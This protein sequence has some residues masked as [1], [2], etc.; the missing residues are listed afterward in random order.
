MRALL[1]VLTALLLLL[2]SC[3][4]DGSLGQVLCD[5][6]GP[7]PGSEFLDAFHFEGF[8]EDY[9]VIEYDHLPRLYWED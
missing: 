7:C 6:Q 1:P 9:W 2:T 5:D 8:D 3:T 4:Y